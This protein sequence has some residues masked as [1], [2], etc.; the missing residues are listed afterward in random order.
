MPDSS[1]LFDMSVYYYSSH[2]V[3]YRLWKGSYT[4]ND[5]HCCV[6]YKNTIFRHRSHDQYRYAHYL[7]RHFKHDFPRYEG[8]SN[9]CEM[10]IHDEWMYPDCKKFSFW[11]INDSQREKLCLAT[12][13]FIY[14]Y[15]WKVTNLSAVLQLLRLCVTLFL[16][17]VGYI[18]IIRSNIERPC[19]VLIGSKQSIN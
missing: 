1:I 8:S 16:Q 19:K 7:N 10:P 5:A 6:H 3:C 15:F 13:P 4:H 2:C 14:F 12:S 18:E 9:I 17:T 11:V